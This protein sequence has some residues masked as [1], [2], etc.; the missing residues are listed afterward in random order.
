MY[1]YLNIFSGGQLLKVYFMNSQAWLKP[2][3]HF[4]FVEALTLILEPACQVYNVQFLLSHYLVGTVQGLF[5]TFYHM[6]LFS[7]YANHF[8]WSR[9]WNGF[10]SQLCTVVIFTAASYSL[11]TSQGQFCAD[12]LPDYLQATEPLFLC[13][14]FSFLLL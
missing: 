6:R 1:S 2:M 9:E 10:V 14:T 7:Q 3:Y 11:V 13:F 5:L 8:S 4:G 12:S